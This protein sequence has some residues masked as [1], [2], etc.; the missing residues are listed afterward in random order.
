MSRTK[1]NP[2][3]RAPLLSSRTIGGGMVEL[4]LEVPDAFCRAARPGMFVHLGVPNAPQHLLR[5]P[6]S[7]MDLEPEDNLLV[8]G[9]Q[10]KGEGTRLIASMRE[11][12]EIEILG[13]LGNGFSLGG[14]ST[15][16]AIGGGVGVAPMLYACKEFSKTARVTASLGFRSREMV[17]AER[18]FRENAFRLVVATDDGS[19]GFHGN[20]LA[21][22]ASHPLPDLIVACGPAPMLRAVQE[23]ALGHNLHCQLSLEQRMGCGYGACLTCSCKTWD[24]DGEGYSRVCADG[25]VFDAGKVVL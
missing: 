12:D 7:I 11:N 4:C 15:V 1:A 19:A 17:Y 18:D 23:F 6:I 21:A 2:P 25:P 22:L 9:V 3:F 16:W 14:A 5:R 24:E 13:P 20:A 8:L 10:P